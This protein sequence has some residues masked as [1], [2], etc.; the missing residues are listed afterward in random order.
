MFQRRRGWLVRGI[1][2]GRRLRA[3]SAVRWRW[4]CLRAIAWWRA[5][6]APLGP[7]EDLVAVVDDATAVAA[8]GWPFAAPTQIVEGASLDA[9]E[10][11]GLVNGEKGRIVIIEHEGALQSCGVARLR[12]L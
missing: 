5:G 10:R 12:N 7:V 6:A 4:R 1:M 9:Q 11:G 8:G 3:A 2:I